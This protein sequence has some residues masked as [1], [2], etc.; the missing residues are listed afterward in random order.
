MKKKILALAILS[1]IAIPAFAKNNSFYIGANLGQATISGSP[2]S[3]FAK[4]SD[5]SWS[6]LGGYQINK[7]LAA[8]IQY[9]SFGKAYAVSTAPITTTG[10]SFSAL[11]NLPINDM[12]SAYGK[13]GIASTTLK[14][15]C[16]VVCVPA[17]Y[18]ATR[19]ALTFGLG[20]QYNLDQ[21]I[22]I[23]FGYDR[24]AIGKTADQTDGTYGVFSAGITYQF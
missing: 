19:T 24:Y 17:N 18:S 2:F 12:F 3:G 7:H 14:V 1:A 5:N 20:G 9:I 16:P 8:E 6:F 11:G 15:D 22:G 13:L 10:L 4:E 23:R 21:A